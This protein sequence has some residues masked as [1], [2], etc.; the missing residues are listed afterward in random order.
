MRGEG[1]EVGVAAS[2]GVDQTERLED[3]ADLRAY[4]AAMAVAMDDGLRVPID[5]L[6]AED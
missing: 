6:R 3:A 5:D 1:V 2:D 4:R